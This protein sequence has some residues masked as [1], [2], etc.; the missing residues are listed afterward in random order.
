MGRSDKHSVLSRRL[1]DAQHNK[2]WAGLGQGVDERT[3]A[4]LVELGLAEEASREDRAEISAKAGHPVRWA[5]RLTDDGWDALTY[6][7]VRAAPDTATPG[8]GLK[9]V[10]L[11]PSELEAVRRY[12][13]LNGRLR[14]GP[15]PGLE[16]AAE[17]ARFDS[18]TNRWTLHVNEEQMQSMARAFFLER[19][20][21]SIAPANRFARTYGMTYPPR[22]ID[23]IPTALRGEADAS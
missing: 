23:F 17:A 20:E 8:P 13:A 2:D 3:M 21:G 6:A 1:A 16:A 11:R 14:Q 10:L 4:P 12:L 7:R 15:A 5:V 22:P 9:T 19:L 18:A